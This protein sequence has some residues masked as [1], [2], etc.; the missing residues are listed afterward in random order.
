MVKNQTF[1]EK[2][3]GICKSTKN[4]LKKGPQLATRMVSN[5]KELRNVEIKKN[6]INELPISR[7]TSPTS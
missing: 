1:I 2:N 4:K 5:P 3:E 7:T 6:P